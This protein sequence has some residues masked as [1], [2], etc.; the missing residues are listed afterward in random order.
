MVTYLVSINEIDGV[1]AY[2]DFGN[3]DS[4]ATPTVINAIDNVKNRPKRKKKSPKNS[5]MKQV[6]QTNDIE[7]V[8]ASVEVSVKGMQDASIM[9]RFM[10]VLFSDS[11]I[12]CFP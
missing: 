1:P 12:F 2:T 9:S 8:K 11:G 5:Q 6:M 4:V 3:R 7:K 10:I